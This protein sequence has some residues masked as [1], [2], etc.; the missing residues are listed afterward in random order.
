MSVR[1]PQRCHHSRLT[2]RGS[3]NDVLHHQALARA[4]HPADAAAVVGLQTV[5]EISRRCQAPS[6]R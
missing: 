6:R 5:R 1:R 3:T 4:R 2:M